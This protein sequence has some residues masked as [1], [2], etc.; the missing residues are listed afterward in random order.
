MYNPVEIL[1]YA[2]FV[3]VFKSALFWIYL[4]QLKEY[5]I[6]RF[7]DHFRT[8]KGKKVFLNFF[9]LFKVLLLGISF[10]N[11]IIVFY[12]LL[13]LY[14]AEIILIFVKR[15]KRP[16]WTLKTIFLTAA[17]FFAIAIFW[18]L[19]GA[20]LSG[21]SFLVSI[22]LF[23]ILS[24]IIF[25][26]VVLIFQPFFVV[27]RNRILDKAK[28]KISKFLS[29]PAG[30]TA[31]SAQAGAKAGG[32]AGKNLTVIGITGSYGKTS[33][34]EFLTTILSSQF[35][36]LSTK[37]HKNSEIGIAQTILSDLNEKHEV[38]IVEMGAYKK[39]GIELLC[40]MTKPRIGIVTGVNEQHLATFGSMENILSAEGGFELLESLPQDGLLVV[41][42]DNK[43]CMELYKKANI[44]K[45]IYS[46]KNDKVKSDAW[47]EEITIGEHSLDFLLLTEGKTTTHITANILGRH[48]I[49][50]LLGAILVAKELGM[51]LEEVSK[52]C[53]EITQKQGATTLK[54]GI[55]GINIIDSSYSSN[56]DGVMADLDYLNVF[57]GKKV[58]VMPCLIELG[59]KSSEVHKQIGEKIAKVCDMAIITTKDRFE[60]IKMSAVHHGMAE[61][62]ILFIEKP[63]EIFNTITTFSKSGDTVLLE[64]RVPSE[65]IKLLQ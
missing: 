22:I 40:D 14:L 53:K 37:E 60:D 29:A 47:A 3:V 57:G 26:V 48:N 38:F 11:F 13:L 62:K 36:V 9:F 34:K 51:T 33:T 35:K 6:G 49:Q 25:S 56:P 8:H 58:I 28:D 16:K 2:W 61:N 63:K 19:T 18:A 65:L 23:D 43:W 20:L 5:H 44:H 46:L 27:G 42:G 30:L 54:K 21:R 41:N 64:G 52:A 59:R 24:P 50:N 10:I 15:R 7:L 1:S 55:H 32:Q 12:L 31:S 17:S 4:W 39:G 45:M